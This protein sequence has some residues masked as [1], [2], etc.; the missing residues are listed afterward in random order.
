MKIHFHHL[1]GWN[2]DFFNTLKG[3]FVD[4]IPKMS[5]KFFAYNH[6]CLYLNKHYFMG[7]KIVTFNNY[8]VW[9]ADASSLG[10]LSDFTIKYSIKTQK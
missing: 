9:E 8:S 2:E 10:E 6:L 1:K 3:G 7:K 4:V 5:L